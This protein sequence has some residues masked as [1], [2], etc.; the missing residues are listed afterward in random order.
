MVVC[1]C[2]CARVE[3]VMASR[4][5]YQL[6]SWIQKSGAQREADSRTVSAVRLCVAPE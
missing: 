1:A 6:Q 5:S 4:T 2:T 3:Y